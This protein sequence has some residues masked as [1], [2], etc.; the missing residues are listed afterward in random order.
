MWNPVNCR[1]DMA[2]ILHFVEG[3]QAL[4]LVCWTPNVS[5][6]QNGKN[7]AFEI[8]LWRDASA[9]CRCQ[10]KNATFDQMNAN[11]CFLPQVEWLKTTRSLGRSQKWICCPAPKQFLDDSISLMSAR[12]CPIDH[13]DRWQWEHFSKPWPWS[14]F[15]SIV[16]KICSYH[17]SRFIISSLPLGVFFAPTV[18]CCVTNAKAQKSINDTLKLL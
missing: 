15:I 8:C 10:P 17:L 7:E 16:C 5:L 6:W 14:Q 3:R 13:L 12:H 11:T 2:F 1:I 4:R 18:S 9:N